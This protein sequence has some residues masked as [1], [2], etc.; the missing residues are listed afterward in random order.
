MLAFPIILNIEQKIIHP[1]SPEFFSAAKDIHLRGKP[2]CKTITD[3]F[4]SNGISQRLADTKCKGLLIKPG[5]AIG[6]STE[7]RSVDVLEA[8]LQVHGSGQFLPSTV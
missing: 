4:G 8:N 7:G 2:V 5:E 6:G 1:D 3:G